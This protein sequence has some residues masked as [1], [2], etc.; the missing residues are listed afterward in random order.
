MIACI[1]DDVD[2]HRRGLRAAEQNYLD[3]GMAGGA[4]Q[5]T[6]GDPQVFL[7][8]TFLFPHCHG[9]SLVSLCDPLSSTFTTGC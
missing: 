5:L 2:R 4:G 9:V 7:L 1:G 6:G 8:S 3:G